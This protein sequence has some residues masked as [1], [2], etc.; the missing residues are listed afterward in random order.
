MNEA[1]TQYRSFSY[2]WTVYQ[3]DEAVLFGKFQTTAPTEYESKAAFLAGKPPVKVFHKSAY[4]MSRKRAEKQ[5]R[6]LEKLQGE[7]ARW[8]KWDF[9]KARGFGTVPLLVDGKAAF[10]LELHVNVN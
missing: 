4:M 10:R 3:D 9:D 5:L 7:E 6:S 1:H 2:D 8:G